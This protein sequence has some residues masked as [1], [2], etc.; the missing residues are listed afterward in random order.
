MDPAWHRLVDASFESDREG[1]QGRLPPRRPSCPTLTG[2]VQRPG[3]EIEALEG[4]LLG[5][6][7]PTG[8]DRT[9][10]AGIDRLDRVRRADHA[11]DL[12][13]VVEER[14]E[15]APR[16]VP[17]PAD[18]PVTATKACI[19]MQAYL[20]Q[21]EQLAIANGEGDWTR[22]GAAEQVVTEV[23]HSADFLS[24]SLSRREDVLRGIRA[25]GAGNC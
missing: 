18:L 17:Q 12:D 13:V 8:P 6:E 16:V 11:S 25:A 14:D 9:P 23:S 10:V 24:A 19:V 22:A 3:R 1:V 15:L 20:N 4:G 5:R 2:R 7:V 21:R